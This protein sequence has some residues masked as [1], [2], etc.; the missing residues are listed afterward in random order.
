MARRRV[1]TRSRQHERKRHLVVVGGG[2]AA[3]WQ[4]ANLSK[5]VLDSWSIT[6]IAANRG[7]WPSLL[8]PQ[9]MQSTYDELDLGVDGC[10]LVDFVAPSRMSPTGF[11]YSGYLS[12]C[13][14]SFDATYISDEVLD[15]ARQHDGLEVRARRHAATRAD[16]VIL[17]TGIGGRSFGKDL[18]SFTVKTMEQAYVDIVT[19]N[20]ADYISR[21][22]VVIGSGNS[23]MQIAACLS[24]VVRDVTVFGNKYHGFFPTETDDR[25]AWRAETQ[26]TCE[27]VARTAQNADAND[28]GRHV[29]FIIYDELSRCGP[30]QLKFRYSR[31]RNTNKLGL[32]SLPPRHPQLGCRIDER[33]S[34]TFTESFKRKDTLV[35]VA[36]GVQASV[37]C[38]PN[39][40]RL[41]RNS[42]GFLQTGQCGETEMPGLYAIGSCVGSPAVN[43]MSCVKM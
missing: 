31:E 3:V 20:V 2:P 28:C 21:S 43:F 14:D 42:H 30:E 29:R 17:A 10:K 24:R 13:I 35:V 36:T 9:L 18:G 23:A 15:V 38:G 8:G 4:L 40:G 39:L 26:R 1:T 33:A 19:R 27:L 34:G 11:E 6:V 41:R 32:F 37:S 12:S 25:F 5:R 7:G 16:R 22:L